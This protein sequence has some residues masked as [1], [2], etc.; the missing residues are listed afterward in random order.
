M[1]A[2]LFCIYLIGCCFSL[3]R[4]KFIRNAKLS[5]KTVI[6]LFLVKVAA[7]C[8]LGFINYHFITVDTDYKRYNLLG[9]EEYYNLFHRPRLFFTDIF[10]PN[11]T[12]YGEFF[13]SH[14][15]YWNDLRTNIIFKVLGVMDIFSRGNYYIN[16]LF[17]NFLGF[18]GHVALYRVFITVYPQQKMPA[19][20][21]CFLLPS[22]LY[23]T[24]GIHKDLII[25]TA[26]SVFS[27]CLYFSFKQAFTAKRI[28]FLIISFLTIL[29]IRN[30]VAIILL[31]CA[32]TLFIAYRYALKPIIAFTAM[33]VI[34]FG[35]ISAMH[36]LSSVNDPLNIV[37]AKQQ[38]FFQ[39][40]KATTQYQ[41]DTLVP[42]LQHFA[43]AAPRAFRH[44][45]LSPYPGEFS[46]SFMNSFSLEIMAYLFAF[47]LFF[48]S[49]RKVNSSSDP[50]IL[51]L[52]FFSCL[53]LL[54][55]GYITP[56][57]GALV[58]YRSIYLPF[59]ITPFIC[60][61]NW[62]QLFIKSYRK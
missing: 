57:A 56:S 32:I 60:N 10:R 5:P 28:S 49:S 38:A 19:I 44:S 11:Y 23:F 12:E 58:R 2:V 3:S 35:G 30:F 13:G 16:S 33:L 46:N 54:I 40:G 61:V 37:V 8:I 17:F 51:F 21:G 26:L 27:Y 55:I 20:I 41:N 1:T 18:F 48:F 22:A 9:F 4:I 52:L 53:V 15:S 59:I 31:P 42:T 43:A 6:L 47:V 36:F 39:L 14:A 7:G 62:H 24:S 29:L 45:F 25:F 34:L 50:F